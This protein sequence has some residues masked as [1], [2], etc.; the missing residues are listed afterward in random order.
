MPEAALVTQCLVVR[1]TLSSSHL[2]K[3]SAQS[4]CVNDVSC[5]PVSGIFERCWRPSFFQA[6]KA[7]KRAQNSECLLMQVPYQQGFSKLDLRKITKASLSGVSLFAE[8]FENPKVISLFAEKLGNLEKCLSRHKVISQPAGRGPASVNW[9][10]MQ[11]S[12]VRVVLWMAGG[13]ILQFHVQTYAEKP[14]ARATASTFVGRKIQG[15]PSAL[16]PEYWIHVLL[17]RPPDLTF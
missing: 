4:L 1:G 17:R 5:K 11:T 12:D 16:R 8:K 6:L 10:L 14:S 3:I 9:N 15:V 13:E 7:S 2:Y